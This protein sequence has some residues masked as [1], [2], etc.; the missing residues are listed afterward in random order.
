[1]GKVRA[2]TLGS[3]LTPALVVGL[4]S[5]ALIG[6][7]PEEVHG[8]PLAAGTQAGA[9]SVVAS[10]RPLRGV[11]TPLPEA[12]RTRGATGVIRPGAF[13]Q[14]AVTWRG[15]A[16]E[17]EVSTRTRG[18]WTRW[19]PLETLEDLDAGE[20]N[21]RRG[22]DL[23]PV[24]P[25][26]AVR[27]KVSGGSARELRVVTIDPGSAPS[28]A[29][30]SGETTAATTAASTTAS[31]TAVE[32]APPG[33]AATPPAY[34]PP[35]S[36]APKPFIRKRARWGA[37][38]S[39]R[40]DRPWFNLTLQQ[41]HVHHT[42]STNRYSR[43][44]VPGIIRGMYWYHTESLGW[45]DIGYNFLI[46]RFGRAWQ[47]RYGG[48]VTN[49]RGA[50]TLGFNHNSFGVAM[51]GN[52]EKAAPTRAAVTKLVKLGAWKL[53]YYR[54]RPLGTITAISQGSDRYPAGYAA[55]LR[56]IDG[57]RDTNQTACPGRYLYEKL[58]SIRQRTGLRARSY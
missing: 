6:L 35:T 15:A 36:Y 19:R 47:G 55:R 17:V 33:S 46:D 51:I 13:S 38:E 48:T 37:N 39:L 29:L 10:G 25:S 52:F 4:A 16:P 54:L 7:R 3:L 34:T 41:M 20:G 50:H 8:P 2:H 45:A 12:A 14:V 40:N 24:G 32:T 5:T 57:H 1:M 30:A 56:V 27:V 9:G 18:E 23:V 43:E 21:G 31:P 26:D 11:E 53:D 44:Q 42:A 49:V 28:L 22:T 58:P